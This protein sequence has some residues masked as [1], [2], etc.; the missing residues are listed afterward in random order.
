M[1]IRITFRTRSAGSSAIIQKKRGRNTSRNIVQLWQLIIKG[2]QILIWKNF[3]TEN[4]REL[5]VSLHVESFLVSYFDI[6]RAS[7][8]DSIL[9]YISLLYSLIFCPAN[10]TETTWLKIY[11]ANEKIDFH[12]RGFSTHQ[13]LKNDTITIT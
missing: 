1:T 8:V 4:K 13:D 12:V 5:R 9:F 10:L 2:D 3:L 6:F 11:S 7:Y